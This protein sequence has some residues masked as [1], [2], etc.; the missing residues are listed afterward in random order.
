[1]FSEECGQ[2]IKQKN[3]K[4]KLIGEY[5]LNNFYDR[6]LEQIQMSSTD[7]PQHY[8]SVMCYPKKY[9]EKYKICYKKPKFGISKI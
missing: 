3:I 7:L 9:N 1:M 4:K 5:L 6:I 2:F 8:L